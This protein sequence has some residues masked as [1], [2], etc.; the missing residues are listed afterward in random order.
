[1]PQSGKGRR[2]HRELVEG[3]ESRGVEGARRAL[4]VRVR[5]LAW[6]WEGRDVL[7]VGFGLPPG[8]YATV[9]LSQCFRLE[10]R[11]GG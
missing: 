8:A 6:R 7:R 11:G 4:R 1:M 9:V 3:L 2:W 10:D 5:E